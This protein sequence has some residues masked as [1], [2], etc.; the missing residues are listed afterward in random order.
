ME[1]L[2]EMLENDKLKL[3]EG[4]RREVAEYDQKY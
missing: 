4:K 2:Q 1:I 3:E